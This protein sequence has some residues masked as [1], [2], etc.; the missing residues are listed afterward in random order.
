MKKKSNRIFGI[1]TVDV[2]G[3]KVHTINIIINSSPIILNKVINDKFWKDNHTL[4]VRNGVSKIN[5]LYTTIDISGIS[6]AKES[7]FKIL[8]AHKLQ[9]VVN[10]SYWITNKERIAWD[11]LAEIKDVNGGYL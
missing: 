1:K 4:D 9:K 7:L 2:N 5:F 10:E 11:V 8:F 3:M 6:V